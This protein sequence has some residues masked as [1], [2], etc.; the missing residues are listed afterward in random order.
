MPASVV[1][2]ASSSSFAS[3][4]PTRP[5]SLLEQ[6]ARL[7]LL[8]VDRQPHAEAELGVV[9]E[10]RVV[11]GRPAPVARLG[12]GR[13]REVAAVDG[14]A[15][16]GV[17]DEGPVAEELG[18][19]L[20]VRGLAAAGA[21][22]GELEERLRNWV[23]FTSSFT[24]AAIQVGEREEE[25]EVL[26]LLL[27]EGHGVVHVDGALALLGLVLGRADLDAQAAAGAVSG[28]TWRV[29]FAPLHLGALVVHGQEAG[30]RLG[31]AARPGRTWRGWRRAGRR[32][33]TCCTGCRW[34]GPRPGSRARCCASPTCV[35][36]VGQV[37]STGKAETGR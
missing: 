12:V 23:P 15:A 26:P 31:R 36:P 33:R 25:V 13:G 11:P 7:L 19:E 1:W 14:R 3:S 37:P 20:D 29:Y 30:R 32:S 18:E 9:L 22:T 6:L 2:S 4:S 27:L 28:A 17:G 16:G 5:P 34:P 35:V 10:E 21:G 24:L 8:L